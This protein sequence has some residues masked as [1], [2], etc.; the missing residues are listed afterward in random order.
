MKGKELI[1]FKPVSTLGTDHHCDVV[2][3][4]DKTVA[5]VHATFRR[6]ANGTTTVEAA[7]TGAQVL[8]NGV[9]AGQ[10]RLRSGDLLTVGGSTLVFQERATQV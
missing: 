2:V 9:T 8:V 6:A 1:L 3:A 10:Q 7:S 4:K 5:A